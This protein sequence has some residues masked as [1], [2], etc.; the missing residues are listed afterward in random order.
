M[1][2][3]LWNGLLDLLYPRK[4]VL[5]TKILSRRESDLCHNCRMTTERVPF[6]VARGKHFQCC[7]SVFYYK[8]DVASA[9]KKLKF[10]GKQHYGSAF[11]RLLAMKLLEENVTADVITWVPVSRKRKKK[12]GYDQAEEIAKAVGKEIGIPVKGLLRKIRH[13]SAQAQIHDYKN[14]MDNVANVYAVMETGEV[15]GKRIL[16]IDDVITTGATLS[17]CSKILSMA[18]ARSVVCG[19]FSAAG[20]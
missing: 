13:N 9:V 12:R 1:F 4:C 14:R 11:G 17:E 2:K 20:N 16:L 10:S 8:K 18:G 15:H 3:V 6:P 5:C 19:T 7:Y